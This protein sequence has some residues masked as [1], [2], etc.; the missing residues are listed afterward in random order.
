MKL[1]RVTITGADDRTPVSELRRLTNEFPFVEWGILIGSGRGFSR[2]PRVEWIE[3]LINERGRDGEQMRL[4]LH[5]CGR[6]LRE[7]AAGKSPFERELSYK[8]FAFERVQLNWHGERQGDIA[9]NVLAAFCTTHSEWS[10]EIIFQ[11]DGVNQNIWQACARRYQCALLF[12]RS[13]GGGVLPDQWPLASIDLPCGYAGGLSPENVYDECLK[14]QAVDKYL[15][16]RWIDAETNVRTND[17]LDL[18]KVRRFLQ[19]SNPFTAVSGA[20]A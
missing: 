12:D 17:V 18:E 14:I 10:P 15:T 20:Q 4:S 6:P 3:E 7:I 19:Q 13:H 9:E 5:V 1:E 2:F 11:E 8:F 16:A